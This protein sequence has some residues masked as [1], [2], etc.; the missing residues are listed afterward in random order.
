MN[1][2]RKTTE[3]NTQMTVRRCGR[4][5]LFTYCVSVWISVACEKY[6]LPVFVSVSVLSLSRLSTLGSVCVCRLC[7]ALSSDLQSPSRYVAMSPT[8]MHAIS[9]QNLMPNQPIGMLQHSA[10]N[11]HGTH[12]CFFFSVFA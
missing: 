8:R 9:K 5:W 10:H 4:V 3:K 6:S 11:T 1:S 12:T 2:A 7:R